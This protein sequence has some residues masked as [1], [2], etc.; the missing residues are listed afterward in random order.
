[1]SYHQFRLA[2]LI[3][4]NTRLAAELDDMI[5]TAAYL[6]DSTVAE[7]ACTKIMKVNEFVKETYII[8]VSFP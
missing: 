8:L 1:M 4:Y 3:S 6:A 2:I 5:S 7:A